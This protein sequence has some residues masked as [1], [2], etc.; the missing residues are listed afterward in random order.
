LLIG[1]WHLF[2]PGGRG[3]KKEPV[4][5]DTPIQEVAAGT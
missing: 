2:N 3:K 1:I 4:E 5:S